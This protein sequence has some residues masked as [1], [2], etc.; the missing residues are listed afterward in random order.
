M[1]EKQLRLN[2][3]RDANMYADEYF[4]EQ[5]AESL[6]LFVLMTRLKAILGDRAET[7]EL[8]VIHFCLQHFFLCIDK[9]YQNLLPQLMSCSARR[10]EQPQEEREIISRHALWSSLSATIAVLQRLDGVTLLL[11]QVFLSLLSAIDINQEI[12]LMPDDERHRWW[13][14]VVTEEQWEQAFRKL[15]ARLDDWQKIHRRRLSFTIQFAPLLG[16]IPTIVEM[17]G[18]FEQLLNSAC[19]LFGEVLPGFQAIAMGD[20][21]GMATLCWDLLQKIDQSIRQYTILLS[22]LEKLLKHY[23]RDSA[24]AVTSTRL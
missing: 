21:G 10:I 18:A 6:G 2:M 14:H 24:S 3:A 17:D 23:G 20:V 11:R 12:E 13:Q 16:V 4:A 8:E 19:S 9:M 1:Q 22:S 5:Y 7:Q 15:A